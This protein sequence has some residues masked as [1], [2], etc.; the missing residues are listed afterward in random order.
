MMIRPTRSNLYLLLALALAAGCQTPESK[1]KQEITTLRIHAEAGRELADRTQVVNV[2]R[3]RSVPITIQKASILDESYVTKAEVVEEQGV[4]ALRI[5]F[6]KEG[7]WLLEQHSA[8]SYGKRLA[9]YSEFFRP[10]GE[11][12]EA[13]WLAAPRITKRLSEGTLTFTPDATREEA[14]QI[15]LGLVN[16]ARQNEGS[17]IW[18]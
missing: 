14:D 3:S 5:H 13:R 4:F 7:S 17:S 1:Q 6:N 12:H 9:I 8:A 10:G 18:K 11:A 16:V 15:V 2:S